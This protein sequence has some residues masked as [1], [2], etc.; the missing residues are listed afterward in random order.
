MYTNKEIVLAIVMQIRLS[1][2]KLINFRSKLGFNQLHIVLKKEQS[3]LKLLLTVF[4]TEKI[5]LQHK[6][7]RNGRVKTDMYFSELR[8]VIE[9][10]ENGHT[11]RNDD[12]ENERQRKIETEFNCI[13]YRINPD[14]KGFSIFVAISEIRQLIEEIKKKNNQTNKIKEQEDKIK[15][16]EAEIKKLKLL[17]TN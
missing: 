16:L 1:N 17:L 9:V 7:L 4:S 14:K 8:L 6:A 15:E 3:V 12:E 10:D 2:P 5:V 13:F 11:G